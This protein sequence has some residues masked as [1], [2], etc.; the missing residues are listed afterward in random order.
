MQER[1][2]HPERDGCGGWCDGLLIKMKLY[3]TTADTPGLSFFF[4]FALMVDIKNKNDLMS[5]DY[6]FAF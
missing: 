4:F 1:G 2:E 6:L 3:R 5:V